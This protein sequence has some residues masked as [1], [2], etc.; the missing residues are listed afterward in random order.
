[1][2][3]LTVQT[4]K[5]STLGEL[6]ARLDLIFSHGIHNFAVYTSLLF[7]KDPGKSLLIL[8]HVFRTLFLRCCTVVTGLKKGLSWF[9]VCLL[10]STRI[11]SPNE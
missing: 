1:M 10:H 4:L 7:K 6:L 11:T 3:I 5:M 2:V 9:L 8:F